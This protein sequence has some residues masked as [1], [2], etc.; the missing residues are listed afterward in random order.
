MNS[1]ETRCEVSRGEVEWS[2]TEKKEAHPWEKK[3]RVGGGETFISGEFLNK[4][5]H[6]K[7][8]ITMTDD[9]SSLYAHLLLLKWPIPSPQFMPY[10]LILNIISISSLQAKTV[11]I[12]TLSSS[13]ANIE[14]TI[15]TLDYAYR[16][17][18]IKNQPTGTYTYT[19]MYACLCHKTSHH[20]VWYHIASHRITSHQLPSLP[21]HHPYP[22]NTSR[23]QW[24]W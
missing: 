12:A 24:T 13:L 1:E 4:S 11:I 15:S 23:S 7:T 21:S 3:W 8:W 16:A 2:E 17:K 18:N 9:G 19:S 10:S 20:I 6:E 22:N 14:E 5:Q